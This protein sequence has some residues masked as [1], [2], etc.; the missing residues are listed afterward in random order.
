[1]HFARS[2]DVSLEISAVSISLVLTF[3]PQAFI[4]SS[5]LSSPNARRRVTTLNL[6]FYQYEHKPP[7]TSESISIQTPRAGIIFAPK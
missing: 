6:R 2:F 1:M 5:S 3:L 7:S 4:I